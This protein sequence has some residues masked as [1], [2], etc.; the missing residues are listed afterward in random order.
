[1][2]DKIEI[3]KTKAIE[4]LVKE[5]VYGI[6][7]GT[8]YSAIT[9]I[10]EFGKAETFVNS[11]GDL[12]TPSVVFF[13]SKENLIVGKEA[14]EAGQADP[15]RVVDLIKREIGQET[16]RTFDGV[17]YSPERI[18]SLILK[19]LVTDVRAKGKEVDKVVIT[20]PAYFNPS[21]RAATRAA[22]EMA[23]IEVLGILE[24]PVAAALQFCDTEIAEPRNVIVYDLGGG[25]FDVTVVSLSE[26]GDV[27]VVCTD[28]DHRLGGADWDLCMYELLEEKFYTEHQTETEL[29]NDSASLYDTKLKA[30]RVKKILSKKESTMEVIM[31]EGL[32]SKVTV[33][34][35]EFNEKTKNLLDK[36]RETTRKMIDFAKGKGITKIH[37]FLLVGGSTRMPQVQEMVAT[38]F[39][40]EL[41]LEPTLF[42]PDE[43][44]AKGAA[45]YA[46]L[47]WLKKVEDER[48]R[49]LRVETGVDPNDNDPEV[50][51]P[52]TPK[53]EIVLPSGDIKTVASKSCGIR[54]LKDGV[55][56]I[57]NM[58]LKQAPLPFEYSQEIPVSEDNCMSVPLDVFYCNEV[59]K[60]AKVEQCEELGKAMMELDSPLSK[61]DKIKVTL[62]LNKEG[63]VTL[64]ATD[65]KSGKHVDAHFDAKGAVSEADIEAAKRD[66]RA[67]Q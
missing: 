2:S 51:L 38:E 1:M 39:C 47:Q 55:P 18:S 30:E 23:G 31:H 44:V 35:T 48:L 10:N 67:A 53:D 12:I 17:G 27:E 3:S 37:H 4:E 50:T 7:L 26:N 13:E 61:M 15:E 46:R 63:A 11:D 45:R 8:T 32:R 57:Y 43:S 16:T 65:M 41:G 62:G 9:W 36:T 24:E 28:G 66:K 42:D 5:N 52:P 6:D 58:I 40:S 49:R 21:E 54:I 14:K 29:K 22:G 64:S 25:T 60:Y 34:R 56:A 19:R 59:V 20:C 33:T